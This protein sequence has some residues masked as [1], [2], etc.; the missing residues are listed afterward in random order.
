MQ[1]RIYNRS[2]IVNIVQT[3]SM[4]L[5]AVILL[6]GINLLT[7]TSKILVKSSIKLSAFLNSS[8][9]EAITRNYDKTAKILGIR[10]MIF[11][12]LFLIL[13][14]NINNTELNRGLTSSYILLGFTVFNIFIV[15][16]VVPSIK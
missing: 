3:I 2:G 10:D 14:I 12:T 8:I 9:R 1:N 11:G 6:D 16:V 7:K 13:S 4:V 5:S 15:G